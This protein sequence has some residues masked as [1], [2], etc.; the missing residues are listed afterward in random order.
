MS[1]KSTE[2]LG[3]RRPSPGDLGEALYVEGLT[4]VILDEETILIVQAVLLDGECECIYLTLGEPEI[5]CLLQEGMCREGSSLA[6]HL[7]PI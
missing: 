7:V 4:A 3:K 1:A 5:K 6:E 2:R